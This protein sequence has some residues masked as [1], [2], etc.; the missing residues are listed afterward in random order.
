LG[1]RGGVE[2]SF[3]EPLTIEQGDT[4]YS[5]IGDLNM[6]EK[7]KLKQYLNNHDVDTSRLEVGVYDDIVGDMTLDDFFTSLYDGPSTAIAKVTLLE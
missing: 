7:Y 2:L 1:L 3:D 6:L 4:L 5:V